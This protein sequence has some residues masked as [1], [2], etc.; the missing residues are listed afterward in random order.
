MEQSELQEPR[1]ALSGAGIHTELVSLKSDEIR[2][3]KDNEWGERV[4][5]D[6]PI[7]RAHA[8]NYDA[9]VLPGGLKNLDILRLDHRAVQF[10]KL[11]IDSGKPV[12]AIC[13]GPW[14]LAEADVLRG[15]TATSYQSIRRDL[16]NA[17]ARWVD[18]QVV[19]YRGLITRRQP[20]DIPAFAETLI[21]QR[22][23]EKPG[24]HS[25]GQPA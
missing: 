14:L 18:Q 19:N 12:A 13:P 15:R 1:K 8:E 25:H 5:V 16:L 22:Q 10:V 3:W 9:L 7:S 11:F 17:G 23:R 21:Q 2:T 4:A 24:M 6:V 20:S